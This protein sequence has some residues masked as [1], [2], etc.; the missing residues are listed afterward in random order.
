MEKL[1]SPHV[2]ETLLKKYDLHFNKRFGQ[3]F[4]IDE[5]IVRKIAMAGE[6]D[7]GDLVLEIGSG[8]GTLTQVLSENAKKVVT[9][10]IDKKLIP[11]LHETLRDCNNVEI[12][13][14]DI[15]KTNVREL[16]GDDIGKLPIKIV[17]NLPYYIT[18]PIIMGFLESDLPIESMTFLIQKEVGERICGGPGTKAYGSLS[19]VA[20]FYADIKLDFSVPSH[21]FIPRPKVDSVVVTFKKLDSPKFKVENKELFLSVVKASFLN[22]RKTLINGLTMNTIFDK[23]VLLKV[24]EECSIAPGIRGETLTGSEFANIANHLNNYIN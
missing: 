15:L 2:I 8:I 10:E 9:V 20:Q 11:V 18:T 1:T 13:Q 5:N 17:A 14:G 22:R 24:L 21:V 4:L 23:E 3:N 7:T 12:I 6:V 19:I 16:L